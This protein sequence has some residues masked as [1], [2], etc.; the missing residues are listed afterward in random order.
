MQIFYIKLRMRFV[1]ILYNIDF[2]NSKREIFIVYRYFIKFS[3]I[4]LH[5]LYILTKISQFEIVK[6]L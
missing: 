4:F 3:E 5:I 2:T 1:G 6:M